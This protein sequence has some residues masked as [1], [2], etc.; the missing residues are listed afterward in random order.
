MRRLVVSGPVGDEVW[1]LLGYERAVKRRTHDVPLGHCYSVI[2]G[3]RPSA[4]KRCAL[5]RHHRP[6]T[7]FSSLPIGRPIRRAALISQRKTWLPLSIS[8]LSSIAKPSIRRIDPS[9]CHSSTP[10][11]SHRP[12]LPHY[13]PT[14]LHPPTRLFARIYTLFTA[15]TSW[16][17]TMNQD[18]LSLLLFHQTRRCKCLPS[19]PP[20]RLNARY[21]QDGAC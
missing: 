18:H 13:P 4:A 3:N 7:P 16:Q 9:P 11:H 19:R 2:S 20:H 14:Q 6:S 12:L 15:S 21:P 5:S 17:R 1:S 10:L 8:H